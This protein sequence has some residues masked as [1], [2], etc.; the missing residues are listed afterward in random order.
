MKSAI[1]TPI[2]KRDKPIYKEN[3]RPIS[4]LPAGS[5][6]LERILH[7]QIASHVKTYLSPYGYRKG[8]CAKYTIMTLLE[9]WRL[10]L[11]NKAYG[12]AILKGLKSI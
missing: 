9:K 11:D 10:S 8:Y 7:K 2:F 12:G 1:I 5:K 3:Y 6:I 4:C